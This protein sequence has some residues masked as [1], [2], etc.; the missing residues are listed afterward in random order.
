MQYT[1]LCHS[2]SK[3]QAWGEETT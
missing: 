3:V 1:I 2:G